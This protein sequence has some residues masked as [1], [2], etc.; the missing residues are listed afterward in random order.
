MN[1]QQKH[2]AVESLFNR[3]RFDTDCKNVQDYCN[4]VVERFRKMY[5]ERIDANTSSVYDA[6]KRKGLIK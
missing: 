6:L 5:G 3:S 2:A 4:K 1:E